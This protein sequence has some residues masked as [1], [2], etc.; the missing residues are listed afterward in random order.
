MDIKAEDQEAYSANGSRRWNFSTSTKSTRQKPLNR[1]AWSFPAT[2]DS[3]AHHAPAVLHRQQRRDTPSSSSS[4]S[5][6]TIGLV[7]PLQ[8]LCDAVVNQRNRWK[9]LA[10][11]K[12]RGISSSRLDTIT[13]VFPSS[14]TDLC[15][16]RHPMTGRWTANNSLGLL[17]PLFVF[18]FVFV[19]VAITTTD[20]TAG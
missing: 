11:D 20:S 6:A 1:V 16:Q 17:I 9:L 4:S 8:R 18:V 5:M 15:G 7:V 12:L 14:V 13:A 19:S 2:S 10:F 3:N